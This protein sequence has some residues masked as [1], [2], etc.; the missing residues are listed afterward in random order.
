MEINGFTSD[1]S[2]VGLRLETALAS[3][4]GMMELHLIINIYK[5]FMKDIGKMMIE[6]NM[7]ELQIVFK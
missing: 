6:T 5:V 1:S 2:R 3:V 4:S 7:E